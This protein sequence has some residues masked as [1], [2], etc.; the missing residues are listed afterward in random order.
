MTMSMDQ[1]NQWY[2]DHLARIPFIQKIFFV[3]HLKT[4]VHAGL[5]LVE[6]LAVLSKEIENKKL[7]Q[8]I[9]DIKTGVERGDQ[10]SDVLAKYP[11]AFPPIYV[12]MIS[13]GEVSGKLEESLTQITIQMKK[14]YELS[15]SIR[16]AMIYPAVI[17]TAMGGIGIMMITVVL[18]KLITIFEEFDSELPLP[19]RVLIAVTNFM[20]KPLNMILVFALI[21]GLIMTFIWA[22]KKYPNFKFFIHKMNLHLPIAGAVIKKINLAQFSLTLSS[23]L[24]SAI[25][26]ADALEITAHTCGN[27]LYRDT[28]LIAGEKIKTGFPLS[29]ILVANPNLFPPMVTEMIMVGEKSGAVDQ[30]L[31]E[32]SNF[33]ST[34]VDKTMKN[35]TTIIEPVII[36]MLGLAV[37]GMAVAII[38][39][40]YSLVQNF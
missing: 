34:E 20:S 23:L 21:I 35:F 14:S 22:L 16:S 24:N 40:M 32:L 19:T 39:P 38:M 1:I 36:I 4:M 27:V 28:L 2:T 6:S 17:L 30:L 11:K 13:A 18:P 26:I 12:K 8:I 10:L 15:S 3:D 29:D 25:P 5:S 37:A 9:Q 31:I 33:Y 7:Q